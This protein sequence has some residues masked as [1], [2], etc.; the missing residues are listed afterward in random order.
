MSAAPVAAPS[1]AHE[2]TFTQV[3]C[4]ATYLA[5]VKCQVISDAVIAKRLRCS[6]DDERRH[7]FLKSH[8]APELNTQPSSC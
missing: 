2:Y 8:L 7:L 4:R 1:I 3:G 6:P 5:S